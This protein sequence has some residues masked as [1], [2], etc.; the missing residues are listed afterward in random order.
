MLLCI[1]DVEF[2]VKLG[3]IIAFENASETD[4][5]D[6]M[7]VNVKQSSTSLCSISSRE[8]DSLLHTTIGM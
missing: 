8:E 5:V 3:G 6:L 1:L 2:H 7:S 4:H